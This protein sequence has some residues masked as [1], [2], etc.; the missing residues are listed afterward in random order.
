MTRIVDECPCYKDNGDCTKRHK[1]CHSNCFEYKTW[2]EELDHENYKKKS[3]DNEY[4]AYQ[5]KAIEKRIKRKNEKRN[6]KR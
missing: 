3:Q 6:F 5:K 1:D 2:R 4:L